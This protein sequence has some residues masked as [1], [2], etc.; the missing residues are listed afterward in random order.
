MKKTNLVF[1]FAYFI[2]VSSSISQGFF[3]NSSIESILLGEYDPA[4]Y[5][6][7]LTTTSKA[8]IKSG[9]MN[10]VRP[11]NL[12]SYLI[13]MNQFK[14]RNTGSDTLGDNGIG[15]ARD[16]ALAKFQSFA[17][18]NSSPLIPSFFEFNRTI[19]GITNHKNICAI[20]PGVDTE[21]PSIIII[22]AHY[23]SRCASV[24]DVDCD[25]H[26]MEDNASGSALVLEL[27]RVMSQYK[28]D[29]TILYVLTVGEEQ[30]LV[31]ADAM[32]K[33]CKLNGIE[34]KAVFNNDIV[35]G[36][37]CGETSSSPSCPG[38]GD[39]DS[40]QVRMFSNGL[41]SRQ[42]PRWIKEQYKEELQDEVAVPMMLTIM[43]IED[44]I[45]RGGDHIPFREQGFRAMR[46]TSANEH[47]DANAADPDYHDRQHTSDDILG[48]DTNADGELD[49]FFVDFNYLGRNAVINGISA[50]F[51][52]IGPDE[53][54]FQGFVDG[55]SILIE[56]EDDNDYLNYKIY[57]RS[58]TQDFDT[59]YVV[60]G[61]KSRRILKNPGPTFAQFISVASVDDNGIESLLS[62]ENYATM[63]L[64]DGTSIPL[65]S[66]TQ[67]VA[68][69][70]Q[71]RPNPFD[72]ATS[73]GYIIH[74]P[75]GNKRVEI[76]IR[77][78][79]GVLVERLKAE[80]KEGVNEVIYYHG[81]NKAG[82]FVYSIEI[83]GRPLESKMM[84]FAY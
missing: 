69:L 49:S 50:S 22:E 58:T 25:A 80:S 7:D 55:D 29:Q 57:S 8:M 53:V 23:D 31:G 61:V 20:Q 81:Y 2:F 1:I 65:E 18:S 60:S 66:P 52:A 3:T 63:V 71:N 10:E 70:F 51:A 35:G 30:G 43:S 26:G 5:Y 74:K 14:T 12:K 16:Y 33:Y 73:I 28:F 38:E 17:N 77:D 11:D 67:K 42:M 78:M 39:V 59:M 32:A 24:C 62:P 46:F 45:G 36:I 64:S 44:R 72:E 83:D 48:M 4:T 13:E 9:I 84:I 47:G 27:A 54:G 21:D 19:C 34:V 79:K 15:A 68:T 37:V 76:V 41:I 75:L 82:T 6:E 40:T 56:I